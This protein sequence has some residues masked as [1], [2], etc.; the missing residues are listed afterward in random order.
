M[1]LRRERISAAVAIE[2][3]VGMQAQAPLAP[4]VGLWT[5]IDGFQHD[6]L[7]RLI[8]ERGAV[9]ASLMRATIHLVTARDALALRP[10]VQAVLERQFKG[11]PFAPHLD[12]IDVDALLVAGRALLEEQPRTRAALSRLL[13][14]RW[15]DRNAESLAYAITFRVPLVQVPPR[16]VWGGTGQATWTPLEAWLDAPLQP[17]PSLDDLVMRYLAAFG[18]AAVMDIQ[19]WSGL[20]RLGEIVDRLRPRLRTFHN[21]DG[22]E[23]FD[24]PDAPQPDPDT[25]A[26]IRFLPEYDNLLLSHADRTRVIATDRRTP[27][28]PGNGAAMGTFLVDGF[29]RGTWRIARSGSVA[30]LQIEPWERLSK[31]DAAALTAEGERLLDFAAGDAEVHEVRGQTP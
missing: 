3:M 1:L 15:P 18:P 4:Y 25:P 17:D 11:S 30:T 5:R 28:F 22:K 23:L 16:G 10:A 7:A 26:P 19:A 12:G 24:L 9:R 21:E 14:E 13:A 20:T 27:L 29:A 2:R 6:E 8:E 31:K